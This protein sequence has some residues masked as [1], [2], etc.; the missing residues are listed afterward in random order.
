MRRVGLSSGRSRQKASVVCGGEAQD[1]VIRKVLA[2]PG[3][4]R[5]A[6]LSAPLRVAQQLKH[7][8]GNR[9]R[10]AGRDQQTCNFGDH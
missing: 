3:A 2:N 6:H 10:V 8:L 1:A 5:F 9:C 4:C 7:R